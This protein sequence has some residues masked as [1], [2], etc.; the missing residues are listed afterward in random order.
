MKVSMSVSRFV[1]HA[2]GALVPSSNTKMSR[3]E[4]GCRDY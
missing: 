1:A 4:T 2:G 3:R